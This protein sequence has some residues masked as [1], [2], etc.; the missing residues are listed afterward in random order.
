MSGSREQGL[1]ALLCR[2]SLFWQLFV[3][4]TALLL[5]AAASWWWLSWQI[6]TEQRARDNARLI[7]SV[8]NLT[9]ATLRH[10]PQRFQ[11]DLM[12]DWVTLEGIAVYPAD[13]GDEVEPLP[14]DDPDRALQEE[15]RRLLGPSTQVGK[16]WRDQPGL[17]VYFRLSPD[18][19]RGYW[20]RFPPERIPRPDPWQWLMLAGVS[21]GLALLGAFLIA[22]WISGPLRVL[23]RAA[24][25]VAAGGQPTLLPMPASAELAQLVLAFNT[26]VERL[27]MNETERAL[28]LAGVSHDVRTP[29]TRLRLALALLP[30]DEHEAQTLEADLDDIDRIVGQFL[31]YAKVDALAADETL[32]LNALVEEVVAKERLRGTPIEW[33]SDAPHVFVRANRAALRRVLVNLIDNAKKYAGTEHPIEILLSEDAA[34]P[35]LTVADRGPGI[36]EDQL[37]RVLAPFARTESAMRSGVT[38]SGLGLAIVKRTIEALGGRL[39][40]ANRDG[41]GLAVTLELPPAPPPLPNPSSSQDAP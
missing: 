21:L 29:L 18:D 1:R 34:V 10:T 12:I 32:E 11:G 15:L 2:V 39:T 41:G 40:L 23:R 9:R 16:S 31:D 8:I 5:A 14:D 33:K 25:M 37:E 19:P 4:I 6:E 26:M 38:G 17:W 22:R 13:F 36:P 27:R 3:S 30:I 28:I 35:T 24:E 20:L 7:A